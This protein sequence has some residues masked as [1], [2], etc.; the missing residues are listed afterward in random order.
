MGQPT[1][2]PTCG[3]CVSALCTPCHYRS[4]CTT[5]RFQSTSP[6]RSSNSEDLRHQAM[7]NDRSWKPFRKRASAKSNQIASNRVAFASGR[8]ISRCMSRPTASGSG[9]IA[10]NTASNRVKPRQA[11]SN[12]V[13]P[14]QTA[15]NRVYLRCLSPRRAFEIAA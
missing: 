7:L 3:A 2:R 10:F 8:I 1:D 6:S 15:S 4:L 11:A 5:S 14:R 9:Q 12:R 13:K